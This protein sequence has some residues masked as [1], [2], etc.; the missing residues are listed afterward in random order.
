MYFVLFHVFACKAVYSVHLY[1]MSKNFNF[2]GSCFT[3][4][5]DKSIYNARVASLRTE[6]EVGS[7]PSAETLVT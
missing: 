3:T 2:R 4:Q 1:S 6:S 7:R 5:E